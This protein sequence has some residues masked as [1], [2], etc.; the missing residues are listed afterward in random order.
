MT[1]DT[2][3]LHPIANTD[4]Q[5]RVADVVFVH[6]PGCNRLTHSLRVEVNRPSAVMLSLA[7][8]DG[9]PSFRNRDEGCSFCDTLRHSHLE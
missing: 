6:R 4:R 9:E 7:C 3:G 5:D 1:P 8:A 2:E